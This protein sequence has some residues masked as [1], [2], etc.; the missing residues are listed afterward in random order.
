MT[1]TIYIVDDD[2]NI[3][4]SMLSLL[5]RLENVAIRSFASGDAFLADLEDLPPGVLLLDMHMPGAS[6][7]DVLRALEAAGNRSAA[8]VITGQGDMTLAVQSM[9]AG[10]IDFVEKPFDHKEL[11]GLIDDGFARI[12]ETNAIA[13]R[14]NEARTRVAALSPR[15]RDVLDGLI[16]GRANK[17]IAN[18]HGISPRTIEIY[19]ANLMEK[20]EAKTLADVLRIAF[21]AGIVGE[22]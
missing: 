15:E 8:V 14:E 7:L 4:A 13:E 21:A 17:V 3:R 18:D 10:A 11:L 1:R 9:K 6:G 20:L 2:P 19:R 12:E 16:A 22:V 5:G